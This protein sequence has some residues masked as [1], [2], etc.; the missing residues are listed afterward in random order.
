[1]ITVSVMITLIIGIVVLSYVAQAEGKRSDRAEEKASAY[2]QTLAEVKLRAEHL[3][4]TQTQISHIE[5][6][7]DREKEELARTADADL[8]SRANALFGLPDG[9]GKQ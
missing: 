5:E 9:S 7:A 1:M 2:S 3:R 8:V 4:E 6:E